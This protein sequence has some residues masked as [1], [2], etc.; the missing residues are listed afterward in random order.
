MA[1]AVQTDN[2]DL[3]KHLP[4]ANQECLAEE[5]YGVNDV[6]DLFQ[7]KCSEYLSIAVVEFDDQELWYL[8]VP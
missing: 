3:V 7:Y 4:A 6:V 8:L 5:P 1:H 2:K